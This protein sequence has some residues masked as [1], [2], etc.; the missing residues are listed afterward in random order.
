M[1]AAS[2]A[3][4]ESSS[5]ETNSDMKEIKDM[6]VVIQGQMATVLSDNRKIQRDLETLRVNE[7]ARAGA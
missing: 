4:P 7:C 5:T 6:L 3:F 2:Q 1:A